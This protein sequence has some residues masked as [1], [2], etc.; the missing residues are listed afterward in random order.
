MP[1]KIIIIMRLSKSPSGRG[2]FAVPNSPTEMMA[3][4]SLTFSAQEWQ[5]RPSLQPG[6]DSFLFDSELFSVDGAASDLGP[7]PSP[8]P[9]KPKLQQLVGDSALSHQNALVQRQPTHSKT[10]DTVVCM[11]MLVPEALLSVFEW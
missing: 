9:P 8:L 5:S 4:S 10:L 6:F 2:A 1:I 7:Q 11:I 3:G